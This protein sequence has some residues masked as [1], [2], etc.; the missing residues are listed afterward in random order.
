MIS[1]QTYFNFFLSF[2]SLVC[3]GYNICWGGQRWGEE[4]VNEHQR[5]VSQMWREGQRAG[6]QSVGVSLLQRNWDGKSCCAGSTET[7]HRYHRKNICTS[8]NCKMSGRILGKG[9]Y[10]NIILNRC[11]PL[12]N[13]GR[14][15]HFC[16]LYV[17]VLLFYHGCSYGHETTGIIIEINPKII[18][19]HCIDVKAF[20]LISSEVDRE[21]LV[22]QPD[23]I[24][25]CETWAE[26]PVSPPAGDHRPRPF[27][28]Q[29]HLSTLRRQ[30]DFLHHTLLF[31]QRFVW[32]HDW[33]VGHRVSTCR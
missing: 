33:E 30:R 9:W 2:F 20:K 4:A 10:S 16:T 17:L 31:V 5:H 27:H 22:A 8:V 12:A 28:S 18:I 13:R 6:L 21:I 7:V 23:W 29:A 26:L 32:N 3:D 19:C 15:F 1:V 25:K 24:W 14:F 11:K